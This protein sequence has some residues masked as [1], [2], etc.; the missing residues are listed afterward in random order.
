[1]NNTTLTFIGGG[2][3]AGSL[4]GGLITDGW[5]PAR[6]RVADTSTQRLEQLEHQF[7]IKT[8]TS[9]TDAIDQADIMVLA[10]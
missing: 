8:T 10:V 6:I 1:M 5:D 2:N 7:S 3:M 4:I 9:T